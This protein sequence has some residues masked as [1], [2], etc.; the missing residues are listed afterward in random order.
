MGSVIPLPAGDTPAQRNWA[1]VACWRLNAVRASL[2]LAFPLA[3]FLGIPATFRRANGVVT[4]KPRACEQR[5]RFCPSE[6]V[7][8]T[9]WVAAVVLLGSAGTGCTTP[10]GA[11]KG[12]TQ[13]KTT[14]DGGA[15]QTTNAPEKPDPNIRFYSGNFPWMSDAGSGSTSSNDTAPGVGETTLWATPPEALE[16]AFREFVRAPGTTP[17]PDFAPIRVKMGVAARF[18]AAPTGW[19]LRR[20]ESAGPE[21]ELLQD[22]FRII[23]TLTNY[24]TQ[25]VTPFL[26]DKVAIAGGKPVVRDVR[27]LK[28]KG[29][30]NFVECR[31]LPTRRGYIHV[32]FTVS[33]D[34]DQHRT[35]PQM[36]AHI[37]KHYGE[38]EGIC[39]RVQELVAAQ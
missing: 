22:G 31:Y 8:R 1:L 14:Q 38:Y 39:Q 11:N 24:P 30:T 37:R 13:P 36:M 19:S 20:G 35:L 16:S 17:N 34:P 2:D 18:A 6:N 32:D 26:I 29:D 4:D 10:G 33:D 23:I 27:C 15:T 21:L 28:L 5:S 12:D 7:M 9:I 25:S 3:G